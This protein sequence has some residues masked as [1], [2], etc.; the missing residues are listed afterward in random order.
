MKQIAVLAE[1]DLVTG[2]LEVLPDGYGFL[3]SSITFQVR[4]RI[5]FTFPDK[6]I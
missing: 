6:K 4:R 5:R 1:P 3:R 2:V